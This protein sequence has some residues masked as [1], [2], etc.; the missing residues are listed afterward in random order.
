MIEPAPVAFRRCFV[1]WMLPPSAVDQVDACRHA[2]TWPA[3]A[4]PILGT[5]LHV[6]LHYL[7]NLDAD[8]VTSLRRALG[9]MAI[10]QAEVCLDRAGI[11]NDGVA[12]LCGD[13]T[14]RMAAMHDAVGRAVATADC[15]LGDKRQWRPHVTLA[16]SARHATPPPSPVPVRWRTTGIVLA[17]A[18]D[19]GPARYQIIDAWPPTDPR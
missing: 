17:A 8:R 15:A 13:A 6:T 16:R 11:W 10:D 12:V 19:G 9:D 3:A 1:A 18:A 2:W 7:G 14:P 5:D 4:K